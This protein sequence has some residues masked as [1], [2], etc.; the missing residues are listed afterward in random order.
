MDF[1]FGVIGALVFLLAVGAGFLLG[2]KLARLVEKW[3]RPQAS[4]PTES[5]L[6]QLR[7]EQEAFSAVQNYTADQAYGIGLPSVENLG[8]KG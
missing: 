5:A 1:L 4:E 7:Q 2:W 6:A 8:E 3:R